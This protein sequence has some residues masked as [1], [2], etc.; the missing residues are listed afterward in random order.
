MAEKKARLTQ[1][2]HGI[3][4]REYKQG[5]ILDAEH[6][7]GAVEAGVAV[8]VEPAPEET[9]VETTEPETPAEI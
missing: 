2:N 7:E 3:G 5:D 1:A 4:N 8:W 9:P 6:A